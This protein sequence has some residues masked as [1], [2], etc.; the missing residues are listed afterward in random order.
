MQYTLF[1]CNVF[2]NAYF[3]HRYQ[4]DVFVHLY[5]IV[6]FTPVAASGLYAA[7][8]DAECT[9]NSGVLHYVPATIPEH[10]VDWFRTGF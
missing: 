1:N 10:G 7:R 9:R 6:H 5:I 4:L 3:A 2:A 8:R